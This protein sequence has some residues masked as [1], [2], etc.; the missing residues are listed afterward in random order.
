MADSDVRKDLTWK[1][2]KRLHKLTADELFEVVENI[3]PVPEVDP[4][5]VTKGDEESCFDYICTYLNCKTLLD[6]ED[7]GFS[8]LLAL[9]DIINEIFALRVT[10]PTPARPIHP[11]TGVN[12]ANPSPIE[13]VDQQSVEFQ[14]LKANYEALGKKLA[15]H[16]QMTTSAQHALTHTVSPQSAQHASTHTVSPQ[17][18]LSAG[19]IAQDQLLDT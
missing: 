13:S 7:Q 4:S 18:D 8:H 14:M 9:R 5:K 19:T 6:L 17:S 2:K 1:I 10:M 3:T 16:E 15:E 11:G 12:I